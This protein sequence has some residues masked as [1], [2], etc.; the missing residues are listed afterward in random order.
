MND[1]RRVVAIAEHSDKSKNDLHRQYL[2]VH[3]EPGHP[4]A[5]MDALAEQLWDVGG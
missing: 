2:T 4:F 3:S 5:G 1:A